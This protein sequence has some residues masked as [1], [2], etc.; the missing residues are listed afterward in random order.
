MSGPSE[1]F[2]VLAAVL[3]IIVAIALVL[4]AMW[5][6][7]SPQYV[8]IGILMAGTCVYW[9]FSRKRLKD[10]EL[11]NAAG[12]NRT[13][14][15]A[16]AA[17]FFILLLFSVLSVYFR[18]SMYE[19]PLAY[20]ILT[21]LMAGT[22]AIQTLLARGKWTGVVLVQ[23]VILG[24][25]LAWSYLT[26]Y[27]GLLESDPW[28]HQLL[29]SITLEEHHLPSGFSYSFTPLFHT[30]VGSTSL[31]LEVDLKEAMMLSVSLG[32]IVITALLIF[33]LGTL[34]T[35]NLR[36]G[37]L[38]SLVLTISDHEIYMTSTIIPSSLAAVFVLIILL[39]LLQ[40]ERN[41]GLAVMLAVFF[42]GAVIWTHTIASVWVAASLTVGVAAAYL[43]MARRRVDRVSTLALT[44]F[45]VTIMLGWW[46]YASGTMT[47]LS[48]LIR[49]SFSKDLIEP[50][51]MLISI[52]LSE[53]LLNAAGMYILFAL[54]LVGVLYLMARTKVRF[55][56]ELS[57]ILVVPLVIAFVSMVTGLFVNVQRWF[58]YAQIAT[59]IPAAIAIFLMLGLPSRRRVRVAA[60]GILVAVITF[61]MIMSGTASTDN[62]LLAPAL[63]VEGGPTVG[64]MAAAHT[65][66]AMWP[67][68]AV[69][70]AYSSVFLMESG[71]SF[72]L[73]DDSFLVQDY[74]S[75]RDHIVLIRENILDSPFHLRGG[76][77][78]LDHEPETVLYAQG[79]SKVYDDRAVNGFVHN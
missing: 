40:A 2:H 4:Y 39:M 69:D 29:T 67:H 1:K 72:T 64:E 6:S 12:S 15:L 21:S 30:L 43:V 76:L 54:S 57:L 22:V 14:I 66:T 11:A 75:L 41:R 35:G 27:P 62:Q 44:A 59:A 50:T 52:P 58:F 7:Y 34:I 70:I 46:G 20:F 37:L 65:T 26:I 61:L 36:V 25:S 3:G 16:L 71:Y 8:L 56:F 24:M 47:D 5:G 17:A 48:Q 9:L 51:R 79:Y 19:R 33:L 74:G 13:A 31:I 23:I 77:Y 53:Q 10:R 68:P 73:L 60:S 38:G 55:S 78:Q 42:M 18:P 28:Y 49:W 63:V 45:F 32:Q